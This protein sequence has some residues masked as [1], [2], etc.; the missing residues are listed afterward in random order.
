MEQANKERV[1]MNHHAVSFDD[2][3][4][5]VKAPATLQDALLAQILKATAKKF[6]NL[7]PDQLLDAAWKR[8]TKPVPDDS[9]IR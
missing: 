8:A 9:G 4:A 1:M 6:A 5:A 3:K 2:F 7:P